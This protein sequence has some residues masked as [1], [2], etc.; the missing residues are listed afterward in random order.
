MANAQKQVKRKIVEVNDLIAAIRHKNETDYGIPSIPSCVKIEVD[1]Y[2]ANHN[3]SKQAA[4]AE[5]T[6][7]AGS[8]D[9]LESALS[10]SNKH[11]QRK[12][13]KMKILAE[14]QAKKPSNESPYTKIM[15]ASKLHRYIP[16][17]FGGAPGLGKK[18]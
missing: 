12:A 2:A 3:I 14:E 1:I 17:F 18:S 15:N 5:L 8:Y 13:Q 10:K 9:K 4:L 6:K 11:R 7:S 16:V